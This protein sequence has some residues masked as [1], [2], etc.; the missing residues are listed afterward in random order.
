MSRRRLMLT[1]SDYVIYGLAILGALL[2]LVR[3]LF[4]LIPYL[5]PVVIIGGLFAYNRYLGTRSRG[6]R[7]S[8]AP[9]DT[10]ASK[11]TDAKKK[12]KTVPFR[13]IRGSKDSDDE[14]RYH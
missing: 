8:S 6:Y 11:H 7:P 14:H 10:G 12:S 4:S 9:R 3:N 5:I 2:Y 13:V 1:P